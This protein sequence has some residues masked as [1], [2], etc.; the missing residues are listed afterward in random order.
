[1]GPIYVTGHRNPDTDTVAAAIGYAELGRRLH[2][3]EE[4]LPVRLGDCNAQTRWVIERSGAPEPEFLP[5]VMPR[6]C[7]VMKTTFP[8][9]TDDEPIR[10]A[11]LAMAHADLEV[12]PVVDDTGAL[13]GVLTERALAR[14][15]VRETRHTSTLEEA[16]TRV[17][18]VVSAL[19]GEL[20]TGEDRRL[21][22]RV[23]V[24]SMDVESRSG[25]SPGDVVVVG[26]RSEAQLRA[27]ELGAALV[28]ISNCPQLN[29][30]CNGWNPT[31]IRLLVW[32]GA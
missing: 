4:Y 27:I 24:H 11:G 28:V 20:L 13:T 32:D 2:P 30:P 7:D 14:R 1:V 10:E 16:P 25:I 26:D 17:T 12:V 5:H 15:Y 9:T 23:W 6:A 29:N 19:G 8:I 3:A 31:P 18:A 21:S 22:G